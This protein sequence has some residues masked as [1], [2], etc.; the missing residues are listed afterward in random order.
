MLR[1][2]FLVFLAVTMFSASFY[3]TESVQAHGT[4]CAGY[5]PLFCTRY[6]SRQYAC[7][8]AG[9]QGKIKTADVA[10]ADPNV[11]FVAQVEAIGSLDW[12]EWV[13]MGFTEGIDP[14]GGVP[15][16]PEV[17]TEFQR[18]SC[19]NA[20]GYTGHG[21]FG[22]LWDQMIVYYTGAWY[23]CPSNPSVFLYRFDMKRGNM[24]NPVLGTGYLGDP[25]GIFHAYSE[26]GNFHAIEPN[27]T[28]CFGTNNSCSASTTYGIKTYNQTQRLWTLWSE[29]AALSSDP[30]YNR[31]GLANF[32]SFYTS[33]QP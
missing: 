28:Q 5:G 23:T 21:T 33:G 3:G 12:S 14:D 13:Q 16:T 4:H 22:T 26:H 24:S 2:L 20:Y 10:L 8:A 9:I 15:L 29:T 18:T 1:L 11:D 6:Y 27:G 25:W 31:N 7:C 32:Y 19:S 17:Y 30:P